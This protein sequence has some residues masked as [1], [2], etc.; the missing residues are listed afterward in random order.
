MTPP[1]TCV[2]AS[3][4]ACTVGLSVHDEPEAAGMC[5]RNAALDAVLLP[6]NGARL[7]PHERRET[8]GVGA[9]ELLIGASCA[10]P[11]C[12]HAEEGH[13]EEQ[14]EG[15][16]RQAAPSA[17]RRQRPGAWA[18]CES[19]TAATVAPTASET[20]TSFQHAQRAEKREKPEAADER[21]ADRAQRIGE[22]RR[23]DVTTDAA[24][25]ATVEADDERELNAR[26]DRRRQDHERP[27]SRST[28]RCSSR[29]PGGRS[30]GGGP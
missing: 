24:R 20:T 8:V 18:S 15:Q 26:D 1:I 16:A 13:G 21:S 23:A 29:S 3:T 10:D 5:Q 9:F 12:R 25:T 17:A 27:R 22:I 30:A 6:A 11:E 7:G 4:S 28:R 14:R 2:G 19:R